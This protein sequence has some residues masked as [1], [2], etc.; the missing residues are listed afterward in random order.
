MKT[1]INYRHFA[2]IQNILAGL[3]LIV[4]SRFLTYQG[5]FTMTCTTFLTYCSFKIHLN[6]LLV[7]NSIKVNSKHFVIKL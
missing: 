4:I 3:L 6:K 5:Y 1:N 2:Y 7:L